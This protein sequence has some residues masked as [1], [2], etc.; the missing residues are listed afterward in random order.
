MKE[1]FM[2]SMAELIVQTQSSS[3]EIVYVF[4]YFIDIA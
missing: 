3:R 2:F 4:A 1:P